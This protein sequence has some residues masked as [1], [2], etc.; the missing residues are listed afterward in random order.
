MKNQEEI[1][2]FNMRLPKST[3]K[4]LKLEAIAREVSMADIVLQGV[5]LYRKK[6][7]NKKL[8]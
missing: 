5:E 4:Y 7:D 2:N 6:I 3:W 8:T 1:T